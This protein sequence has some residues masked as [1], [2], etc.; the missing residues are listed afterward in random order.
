MSRQNTG[1]GI[2]TAIA[3]L[4]VAVPQIEARAATATVIATGLVNPRGIDESPSGALYVAE[5]GNGGSDCS[6]IEGAC[7]GLSGAVSRIDPTGVQPAARIVTGLPSIYFGSPRLASGANDV[8]FS[9]YGAP[10]VI[11]G[12]GGDPGRRELLG[13]AGAS[14]GKLL[15]ILGD[16]RTMVVADISAFEQA[17]N[18]DGTTVDSNPYGIEAQPSE[19]AVADAGAN[20]LVRARPNG[21]VSQLAVFAPVT[22]TNPLNGQTTTA[23]AVPTSVT[24]GPDGYWYVGTL[25]GF[26]FASGA[27]SVWRVPPEGGTPEL[28]ASGFT[29]IADVAFDPYGRLYVLEISSGLRIPPVPPPPPLRTPGKLKRVDAC[30]TTPVT[31]YDNSDPTQGVVLEYPAGVVIG[32]D[33]AAYVTNKTLD[34]GEGQVIR[35]ALTD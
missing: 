7:F 34:S 31:V 27:A 33:G 5:A 21:K 32:L 19:W 29:T 20:A 11:M 10:T 14:L 23:Q 28:C 25:T 26:P 6:S 17:N 18:P 13:A 12:L 16:N 24:R 1:F 4:A 9:R 22:V 3:V 30:G 15:R 8:S 2:C 35:I